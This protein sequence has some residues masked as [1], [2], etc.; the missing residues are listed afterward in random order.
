MRGKSATD[1]TRRGRTCGSGAYAPDMRGEGATDPVIA[2]LAARQHGVISRAQLRTVGV[3][4]GASDRRW[5]AK[6]VR[7]RLECG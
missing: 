5:V 2:A 1:G 3:R 6:A 4:P 7:K